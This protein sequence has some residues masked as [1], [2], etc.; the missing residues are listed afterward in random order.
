MAAVLDNKD[1]EDKD[2][3]CGVLGGSEMLEKKERNSLGIYF[4]LE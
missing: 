1:G 4:Y 2:A 3:V